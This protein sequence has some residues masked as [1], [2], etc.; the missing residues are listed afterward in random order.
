MSRR[1]V[2]LLVATLALLSLG[3]TA[4][5]KEGAVTKFDNLPTDWHAGQT[6]A[7][8]YTIRMDGIEPYKADRTEIIATSLDGKTNLVFPGV[9]DATPGHYTAQVMFPAAATYKWKVTQGTFF[10]PFDLGTIA[11]LPAVSTTTSS[12]PATPV[13]DPI[14]DALPFAAAGAVVF[15]TLVLARTQRR[16]L[17]RFA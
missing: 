4:L 3:T 17:A 9:A 15:A 7:L 10:A 16:R 12:S 5:A 2:T 8:G 6:Y 11:V 14:R 1:L 13:T